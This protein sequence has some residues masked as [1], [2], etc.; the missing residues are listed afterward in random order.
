MVPLL[1]VRIGLETTKIIHH[2]CVNAFPFIGLVYTNIGT[3]KVI[4]LE[5]SD[6]SISS[7]AYLCSRSFGHCVRAIRILEVIT[8]I[9]VCTIQ[10]CIQLADQ[11]DLNIDYTLA[12]N[13]LARDIGSLRLSLILDEVFKTELTVPKLQLL[14][15]TEQ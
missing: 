14:N 9:H 3:K 7:Q 11:D 2:R 13:R 4:G 10:D 8:Q 1:K 12:F 5:F 6:R 15:P